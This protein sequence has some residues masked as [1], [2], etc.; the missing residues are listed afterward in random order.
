M[1]EIDL[2]ENKELQIEYPMGDDLLLWDE[3]N[4]NVYTMHLELESAEGIFRRQ[5]D[6]GMREFQTEGT[7]FTINGRPIFLRGTLECA[8]FPKTGYPS[9]DV[10]EWA[11]I[12]NVIKAHGLNHMRFHSWCPP[13]AAFIAADK[14]GIYLQVECSGWATMLGLSWTT[15]SKGMAMN[16]DAWIEHLEAKR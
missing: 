7:R 13:E 2:T 1:K 14:A 16:L 12:F 11:R 8:I 10:D 15:T 5:I 6:F 3:F 9:T 4:P